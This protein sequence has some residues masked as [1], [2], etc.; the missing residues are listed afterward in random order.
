MQHATATHNALLAPEDQVLLCV[1]LGYGDVLLVGD[2]DV[3]GREVNVA[4][5]L[6]EDTAKPGQILLSG[7]ARMALGVMEGVTFHP[8][9]QGFTPADQNFSASYPPSPG[10]GE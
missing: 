2:Q 9:G 6:G 3:W 1:G 5:K 8:I 7:A 10:P 4:S